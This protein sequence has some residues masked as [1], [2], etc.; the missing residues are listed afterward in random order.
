MVERVSK[1]T[2][3]GLTALGP[4]FVT[5]VAMASKG[6]PGSTVTLC[7][8]GAANVG[9]GKLENLGEVAFAQT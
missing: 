5:A 4:A 1:L 7:T 6:G 8:D 3:T 9:F 2:T